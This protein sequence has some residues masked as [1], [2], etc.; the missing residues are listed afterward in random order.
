MIQRVVYSC[1]ELAS[2]EGENPVWVRPSGGIKTQSKIQ[3]LLYYMVGVWLFNY[4]AF[5]RWGSQMCRMCGLSREDSLAMST[6]M[7]TNKEKHFDHPAHRS[8]S[9]IQG[10]RNRGG[11]CPCQYWRQAHLFH[12]KIIPWKSKIFYFEIL[13]SLAFILEAQHS[14]LT[15]LLPPHRWTVWEQLT[16]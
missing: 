15:G 10:R 4:C 6:I 8:K 16:V 7:S 1:S 14:L 3:R 2:C 12:P 13:N 5:Y 11:T 9:C